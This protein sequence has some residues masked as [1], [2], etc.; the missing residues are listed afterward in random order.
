MFAN[1]S[2]RVLKHAE[3]FGWLP[4]A[5]YTNL[6]DI[7]SFKQVGFLDIDWKNYNFSRHLE[8]AKLTKP[9]VTVARDVEDMRN[10]Q[11]IL[12]QADKL[13]EHSK[14]VVVA[15]KDLR[16]SSRLM[17]A[18]PDHFVLGYSVPTGYGGT[19]IPPDCFQ[20]PVHLL[21]GRPDVQR[22]L[23]ERMPV[24]SIDCNRFTLDAA[25]GDY[26]DGETFRP[27]PI[28]GY[29]RCIR[30]SLKNITALWTDYRPVRLKNVRRK[31]KK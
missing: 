27:H 25:Y 13:L 16:L 18:I 2:R 8:V 6:R 19:R 29:D 14:R 10:L 20:R 23:A 26:F 30:A 17:S 15:P 22:R 1:H 7:R 5:R 3:A 12:K 24:V 31:V 28:G 4:G 11:G 21:G 9:L